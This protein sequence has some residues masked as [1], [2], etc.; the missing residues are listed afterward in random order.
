MEQGSDAYLYA[1]N[2]LGDRLAQSA[3]GIYSPYTLD[4]VS[5]LTQV[6]DDGEN[7]HCTIPGYLD[8]EVVVTIPLTVTVQSQTGAP[9]AD[10][11][12]Y[13][14]SGED[15]TGY[16]GTTDENGAVVFTLPEGAYR[17]RSDYDGVQFWSNETDHCTV[18]GYLEALV[19]I[20]GGSGQEPVTID[21]EYCNASELMRQ[22]RGKTSRDFAVYKRLSEKRNRR[23]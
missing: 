22:N 21:Y 19:E 15:Y 16:H 9:Y 6:L 11:P 18:P 5:G 1:S 23:T 3:N 10:L 2:G 4:I 14:F 20:P 12:V 8:T 13:V 7:N 17:F